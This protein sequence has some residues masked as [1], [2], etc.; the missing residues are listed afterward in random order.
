MAKINSNKN[1]FLRI[2]AAIV[3]ML[4]CKVSFAQDG[5]GEK[6]VKK[7]GKQLLKRTLKNTVILKK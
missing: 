2:L 3:M 5:D 1:R 4:L 6:N 7:L